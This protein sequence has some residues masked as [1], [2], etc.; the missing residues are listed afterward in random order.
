MSRADDAGDLMSDHDDLVAVFPCDLCEQPA[1]IIHLAP[2]GL[3]V[4]E[5]LIGRSTQRI[6]GP[7][8]A[9]SHAILAHRNVRALY[10]L[11][12]EWA[13]FYCPTCDRSYCRAH[14]QLDVRYDD[15]YPG[16]YDCAYGVC[17]AG[18]RRLVDD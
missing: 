9:R 13:S 6:G 14:W 18:H 11:N 17:P 5:A 10:A 2:D 12:T 15:D 4:V 16:W 8:L 7:G 1:A 3:I